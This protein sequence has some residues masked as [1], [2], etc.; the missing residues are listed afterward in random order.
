MVFNWH[1]DCNFGMLSLLQ[2]RL[3]VTFYFCAKNIT[4]QALLPF[5]VFDVIKLIFKHHTHVHINVTWIGEV[6]FW[7]TILPSK[8]VLFNSLINSDRGISIL[9]PGPS[10]TAEKVTLLGMKSSFPNERN[11][12]TENEFN[13]R[14][15]T[16]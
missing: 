10:S 4:T 7:L 12:K 11:F 8:S 13:K 1:P 5:S 9:L 16:M 15:T 14:K 2:I 3:H 6:K